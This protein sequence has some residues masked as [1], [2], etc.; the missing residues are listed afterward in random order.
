MFAATYD[1]LTARWEGRHG[2]ELRRRLLANA[3]G[4]VL[5]I[6]VGTGLSIPFYPPVDELVATDPAEPMLRRARRRAAQTGRDV[7]LVEAPAERLPFEDDSFD[8]VVS[9][10]VLCTV[11]DQQRALQ[12]IRR[13]LRPGG[14]LLLSEHVRAK[15]PKRARWQDRLEGAW[16]VVANGC[17]PNRRTLDAIRDAG[18][19]VNEVEQGELPGV[20]ALMRPHVS[21]SAVVS[22][23]RAEEPKSTPLVSVVIPAF[24]A[25][26]SIERALE[27]ALTQTLPPLEVVVVD[28]SSDDETHA[29][30]TAIATRD[31]RVRVF[32]NE[33]NLGFSRTMNRA[34]REAR[35]TWIAQLDS[36]DTW[37]PERLERMLA[38][39]DDSD[40]IADDIAVAPDEWSTNRP[41]GFRP[42]SML[43][44]V[45]IHVS[46]PRRLGLIEFL[47]RDPGLVHPIIRNE[48][49]RRH[50]LGFP[51]RTRSGSDFGLWALL[52]ASGARWTQLPD[53]YY[54]YTRAPHALT[55]DLQYI[56]ASAISVTDELARNPQ[57]A[58]HRGARRALKRRK[59]LFRSHV[60]HAQARELLAER[61][62][63]ALIALLARDPR[64]GPILLW[65][66][67]WYLRIRLLAR[68]AGPA[69]R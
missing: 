67:G 56:A 44:Q 48:F 24:N 36:D 41:G 8:T 45:G 7:T 47:R 3:R 6:G 9:M 55:R 18:F 15:D 5:E 34:L 58:G 60:V 25:K 29:I 10:L 23:E 17:H 54:V 42:G 16:G 66:K 1:P 40:V 12:E 64:R 43:R 61:R 53:A 51:E 26:A 28:D 21:G 52:L 37:L 35:G 14:Q 19:D 22:N 11:S 31:Q 50:G 57:I 65:R 69:A 62:I 39:A 30:A 59:R 49:M 2:A 38:F 13:V 63:A 68:A 27:S 20:L 4:R 46:A 32:K 33:T